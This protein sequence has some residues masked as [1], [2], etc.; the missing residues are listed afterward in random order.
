MG[1]HAMDGL[2][3]TSL[4]NGASTVNLGSDLGP[5][6]DLASSSARASWDQIVAGTGEQH[7]RHG[8]GQRFQRK[9]NLWWRGS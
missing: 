3:S 1:T 6:G 2:R 7:R 8:L 4:N 9:H 5:L